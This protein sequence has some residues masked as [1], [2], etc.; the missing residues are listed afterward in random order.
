MALAH[1]GIHLEHRAGEAAESQDIVA[2]R[3]IDRNL[4]CLVGIT[5]QVLYDSL[6]RF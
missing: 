4:T 3:S 2:L 5:I 6:I 1:V